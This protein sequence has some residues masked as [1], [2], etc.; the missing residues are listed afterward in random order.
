MTTVA[1]ADVVAVRTHG[2]VTAD[3]IGY[4]RSKVL[5]AT[6]NSRLPVLLTRVKLTRLADPAVGRRAIVQANVD[7]NGRM[8]RAQVARPS[9]REAADEV[10]DRLRDRIQRA[11]GRWEAKRRRPTIRRPAV[12]R[13]PKAVIAR[14]HD[15][16]GGRDREVVRH[17]TFPL[18][19]QT[20]DEAAYEMQML[21]YEFHLFVER[22]T[23]VDSVLVR[24]GPVRRGYRLLQL[25]PSPREVVRGLV[26]VTVSLGRA[27]TMSLRA[28]TRA[29]EE[30]GWPFLFFRDAIGAR[31]CVVYRRYDGRLGWISPPPLAGQTALTGRTSMTGRPS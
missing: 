18:H 20:V 5:A 31:G 8:L 6:R 27:P 28:A 12:P 23:G 1:P 26:P 21:D 19:R 10:H 14:L 13:G 16:P 9:M 22:G 25:D 4:A 29:L 24:T 2:H 7:L 3:E 11:D 15:Q 30:M 17:K